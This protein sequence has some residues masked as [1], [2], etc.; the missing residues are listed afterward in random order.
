MTADQRPAIGSFL[1]MLGQLLT[2]A[3][4]FIL[5]KT[6]PP[7]LISLGLVTGLAPVIVFII[8]TFVLFNTRY[9]HWKPAFKSIDF[10]VAGSMVNLGFKFFI[11]GCA[12]LV[13]TQTLPILIQRITNPVEV[14]NFNTAFRLF[15]L[16]FNVI[17]IIIMPYWS[18][19]TDAY[20]Q[21]DFAWMKQSFTHL[22]KLFM[23]SIVVQLILLLLSPLIYYLWINSW[24][25]DA[26][27]NLDI[28]FWLSLA[29]SVYVCAL[30]WLNICIYPINGIG[31]IK[32]QV[33]SSIMEMALFI[34]LALW[35]GHRWGTP[36][37]VMAP[38]I[39]YI[40]RMIWAPIQLKKLI[41]GTSRGIWNK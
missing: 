4:I 25:K 3:G 34:P 1:D 39:I 41:T 5:S 21:K 38:V 27:N 7:S 40:P 10:K 22:R 28:S 37:I 20:T 32:L 16:T 2:F 26:A 29:V 30:T 33:Y 36:G 11:T 15:S 8:A 6:V 31:K 35:M 13:V 17:G 23:Y 18:S 24:I 9:K 12:F 14:T 19:F